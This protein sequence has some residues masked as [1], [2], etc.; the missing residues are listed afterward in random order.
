MPKSMTG[1]GRATAQEDAWTLTW[2]IRSLNNRH[3]DLKW[4]IPPA[5]HACQKAWE[6]EVRAVAGR[7]G[8]ELFLNLRITSPRMQSVALDDTLAR[9][10]LDE[11][12]RLAGDMGAAFSPDLNRLLAIPSLWKDAGGA[13]CPELVDSLTGTLRLALAEW[14]AA[15]ACEGQALTEDLRKRFLGLEKVVESIRELTDQTAPERLE[16]LR[17]RVGK[18]LEGGVPS[19]DEDRLLQELAFMADRMDV[20]EELTRLAVHLESVAACLNQDG[21][22]GRKLDFMVQE[23]F[24]E[25]NTCGNKCQNTRISQLAVDFKAELEKCREQIQN[26]E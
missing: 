19:L 3:L 23:C 4:K 16:T 1:F 25:I 20:S 10:M 8:V 22:V 26:L 2:E 18:L 14:D 24:R 6:N 7:G 21:P 9:S 11:L 12:S 13:D 5:F 17:E 15:R